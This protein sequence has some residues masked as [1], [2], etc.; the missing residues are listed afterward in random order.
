MLSLVRA[1]GVLLTGAAL[2][3]PAA[4]QD[5]KVGL[6]AEPSSMDPHYHNLTPNNAF[7]SHIFERWSRWTRS[8]G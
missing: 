2:A 7:L 5:L 1:L 3:L 4:A 6:S 8:S